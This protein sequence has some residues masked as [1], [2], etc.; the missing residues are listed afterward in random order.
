MSSSALN[1]HWHLKHCDLCNTFLALG[2]ETGTKTVF[3]ASEESQSPSSTSF[4]PSFHSL[5]LG[6]V[7]PPRSHVKQRGADIKGCLSPLR[8]QDQRG[9]VRK[10]QNETRRGVEEEGGEEESVEEKIFW[11]QDLPYCSRAGGLD[12]RRGVRGR[13]R[14]VMKNGERSKRG[15]EDRTVGDKCTVKWHQR[16]IELQWMPAKK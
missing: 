2:T 4:L 11:G 14:G 7:I 10:R 1:T 3:K 8:L 13:E 15:G 9:R 16:S 6:T 12:E 5:S